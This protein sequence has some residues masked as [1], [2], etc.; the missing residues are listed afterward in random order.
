[1]PNDHLENRE[2]F[3]K[4]MPSSNRRNAAVGGQEKTTVRPPSRKTAMGK[5]SRDQILLGNMKARN[6][7]RSK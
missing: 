5:G 6:W 2:R 4:K 7:V 3:L 1:L